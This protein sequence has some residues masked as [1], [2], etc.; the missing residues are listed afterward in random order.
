MHPRAGSRRSNVTVKAKYGSDSFKKERTLG[1]A[2]TPK[3]EA[4]RKLAECI[5]DYTGRITKLTIQFPCSFGL[6]F[7][8]RVS[9]YE[10]NNR[11]ART[12]ICR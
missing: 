8:R 7:L 4:Q 2:S 6:L 3:H 5:E 1:P 12:V 10:R 11:L 9:H